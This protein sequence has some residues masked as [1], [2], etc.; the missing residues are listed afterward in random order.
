MSR[1]CFL[2][3]DKQ[4]AGSIS[5]RK[6]VIE[7]ALLNVLTAYSAQEGIDTLR[8]FPNVDGI[9]LDS[10]VDGRPCDEIIRE[11]R[12]IRNDLRIIT[13]SPSGH[14]RCGGEDYHVSSYDP[15]DLLEQLNKVCPNATKQADADRESP[16]GSKH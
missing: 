13:V 12:K 11:L 9:V 15:H 3:I 6:L 1:P 7:T 14:A 10:E 2:V 16:S 5:T 8:R 4:F